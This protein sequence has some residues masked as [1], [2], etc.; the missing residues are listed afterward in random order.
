MTADYVVSAEKTA[1][2]LPPVAAVAAAGIEAFFHFE[3]ESK[4]EG[5]HRNLSTHEVV[6]GRSFDCEWLTGRL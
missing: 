4:E 3:E 2:Q 1:V 5:S 6:E